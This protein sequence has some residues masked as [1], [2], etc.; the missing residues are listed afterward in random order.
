MIEEVLRTFPKLDLVIILTIDLVAQFN[1]SP[2]V[3]G[4]TILAASASLPELMAATV[5]VFVATEN[6]VK[7]G[8]CT[9]IESKIGITLK[10]DLRLWFV[11]VKTPFSSIGGNGYRRWLRRLQST[12]YRRWLRHGISTLFIHC[13]LTA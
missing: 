5:G 2:D 6:S 3:A 9:L 12:S 1:V 10:A 7:R 11:D 8:I 13:S 4:A